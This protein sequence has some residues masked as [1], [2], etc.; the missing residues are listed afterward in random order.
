MEYS[1]TKPAEA[2][3]QVVEDMKR[4]SVLLLLVAMVKFIWGHFAQF[5]K[6]SYILAT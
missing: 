4:E 3:L 1:E 5:M 2:E 6:V